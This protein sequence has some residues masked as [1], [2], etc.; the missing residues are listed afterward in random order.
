MVMTAKLTL[1]ILNLP[2]VLF[3]SLRIIVHLG[4]G[5]CQTILFPIFPENLQRRLLKIWSRELLDILEIRLTIDG[6]LP[7]KNGDGCLLVSNHVSWLDIF[8]INAL[9]P[10]QFV[11]KAEVREWPVIGWL[12]RKTGTHFIERTQRRETAN[13]NS[14]MV[15]ALKQGATIGLFPEGTTTDG[16]HVAPFHAAMLQPAI[17]AGVRV[18]PIGL[19][20]FDR[21]VQPSMTV[22]FTGETTLLASLWAILCS[23]K[24]TARV[25]FITFDSS[26]YADRKSL[27]HSARE[28]IAARLQIPLPAVERASPSSARKH[29]PESANTTYGLL[30]DPAAQPQ[31]D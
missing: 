11:A 30:L 2:I 25:S 12:C 9:H 22:P 13:T 29:V 19:R 27:A 16:S 7:E 20:Y 6:T 24:Q 5:V 3:K 26:N 1:T 18:H 31:R 17:N 21:N 14:K 10:T 23:R 15:Q 8:V 28:A 4:Y